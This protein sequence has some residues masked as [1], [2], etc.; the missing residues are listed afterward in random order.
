MMDGRTNFAQEHELP[1]VKTFIA[2]VV[3][4]ST[5]VSHYI[6]AQS[7]SPQEVRPMRQLYVQDQRDRGVLLS[8]T[9][10]ALSPNSTATAPKDLDTADRQK[11]DAERRER[12]RDFLSAGK[13][14]TAQDFHDAAFIFQHGEEPADYPLAHILAVEAIVKGDASSK[15]IAAAT[16]DRYLQAIGQSQV[17]GTQYLSGDFLF[18]HQHRNDPAA[19]QAHKP[20]PGMTQQPYDDKFMPDTLRLDFCVPNRAQQE[21]NLKDFEAN[22]QPTGTRP[23]G[24]TH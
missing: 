3:C 23:P 14:T 20:N 16:L 1:S 13:L 5:S 18:Y 21:L 12:T 6:Q 10:E 9:G 15:W 4:L 17:F 19:I 8:D 24:C 11:R 22:K 7:T 2:M